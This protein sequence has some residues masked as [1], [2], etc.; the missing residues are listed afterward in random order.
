MAALKLYESGRL[1]SGMAAELA[2]MSRVDFLLACGQ[3]G[4]TVFQQTDEEL[5]SDVAAALHAQCSRAC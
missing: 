2:G 4:V 5:K 1:S 3:H